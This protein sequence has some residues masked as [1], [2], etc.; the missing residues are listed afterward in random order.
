MVRLLR[1]CFFPSL[2]MHRAIYC[3][4]QP[5][6]SRGWKHCRSCDTIVGVRC[7]SLLRATLEAELHIRAHKMAKGFE[8][9][10]V[11][12]QD[13]PGHCSLAMPSTCTH[14]HIRRYFKSGELPP[15]GTIC[16]TIKNAFPDGKANDSEGLAQA[17]FSSAEEASM[18]KAVEELSRAGL[19]YM[20][21]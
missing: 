5:S 18:A 7:C 1:L 10:V 9:A 11:L 15:P 17:V 8:G 6:T 16:P 13:S 14:T 4:H 12:T 3:Q 20:L 19:V 2:M 21:H